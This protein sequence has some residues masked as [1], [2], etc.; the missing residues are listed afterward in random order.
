MS[1]REDLDEL[2]DKIFEER[3]RVAYNKAL[4]KFDNLTLEQK[5]D[6]LVRIY[7]ESERSKVER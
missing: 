6:E 4:S 3:Q 1:C 5:V 2:E 7:A